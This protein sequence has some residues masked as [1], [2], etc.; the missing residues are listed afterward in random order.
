M[1]YL[2]NFPRLFFHSYL[3]HSRDQ[4]QQ[5][6][7]SLNQVFGN[8]PNLV[9]NVESMKSFSEAKCQ[10]VIYVEEK[11][12]PAPNTSIETKQRILATEL[13]NF[14]NQPM[15][16][17]QLTNLG[18]E[19]IIA[20]VLPD[21]DQLKEYLETP[22]KGIDPRMWKQAKLDNPDPSKFIPVP[23]IGFQDLKWR[24]R[25]QETETEIHA[26]YLANVDKEIAELKQRH[27]NTNAKIMAYR[28]K[29]AELSHR[30]LKVQ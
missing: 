27:S 22:P 15:T 8:K 25:C 21:A 13:C 26:S 24:I 14:L 3:F 11:S 29:H 7:S 20:L 19:Q 4:Q 2:L 9:I 1:H 12:T 16:K 6:I 30:V 18:I 17:N 23:M 5:L 10:V 28:R